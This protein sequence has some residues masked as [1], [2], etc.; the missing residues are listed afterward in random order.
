MQ[1]FTEAHC[2]GHQCW[3]LHD[4][5][6]PA[7][8][9]AIAASLGDPLRQVYAAI[10]AAIGRI[11]TEARPAAVVVLAA[12]GMSWWFGAQFLL[13]EILVRLGVTVPLPEALPGSGGMAS[14]AARAA[15]SLPGWAKA[16]LRPMRDAWLPPHPESDTPT[17]G[18]DAPASL[19]F[20]VNNGLAVGGIRLNLAGREPQGRLAAGA[21]ADAFCAGLVGDLL[22]IRSA[23][24]GRPLVRA[25][26]RTRDLCRG[27]WLDELPD[28]LVEWDDTRPIGSALLAG[29]KA[30]TVR[31]ISPKIGQIE[32]TNRYGRTGEHRAEGFFVASGAQ[33]RP[34]R[35]DRAV[36][37]MDFAPSFCARLD[38]RPPACDGRP[39]P[40]LVGLESA[41]A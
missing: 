17:L 38:T 15:S 28:L 26:H 13:R 27:P 34:G 8:D 6:H 22:D 25:V 35:L 37:V 18:V 14:A 36:S 39:I 9:A 11:I 30:A 16:L 41:P 21:A 20:P 3:H 23:T 29:G 19:C 5:A 32:G 12:H 2:A 4:A 7:H 33:I 10:D 31:A 24:D 1:V 40:Q